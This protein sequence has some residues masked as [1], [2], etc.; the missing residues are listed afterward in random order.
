MQQTRFLPPPPRRC[1]SFLLLLSSFCVGI[2]IVVFVVVVVVVVVCRYKNAEC[3]SPDI[4]LGITPSV[5]KCAEACA[6]IDGCAWFI[7]GKGDKAGRCYYEITTDGCEAD[8]H[9]QRDNFDLCVL[10]L[11]TTI[12]QPASTTRRRIRITKLF[13]PNTDRNRRR[14]HTAASTTATSAHHHQH[15]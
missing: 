6:D 10:L 7:Y 11:R 2:I 3:S 8:G 5:E 1:R 13:D 14:H 15:Q 9:P 4:M 12:K